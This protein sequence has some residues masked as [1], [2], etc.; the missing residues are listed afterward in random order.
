MEHRD[1][2]AFPKGLLDD[3]ARRRGD[4]L[5]VDPAEAG[6]EQGDAFDELVDVLG[7]DLDV[8]RV[9][10]G[11]AFEQYRLALHHGF[12]GQRAEI[13]HAEDRGTVR[14]HRDEIALGGVIIGRR[15]IVGDRLDGDRDAGR[16][17]EA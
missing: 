1:V 5:E 11:E 15:R 17:S 14:Y 4:I 9:D 3:E 2:H 10:V 16:I 8:D 12:G 7:I 6:A 13:T